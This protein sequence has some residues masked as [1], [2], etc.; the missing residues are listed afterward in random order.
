MNILILSAFP[1]EQDYYK[2]TL[3]SQTSF[4]I[5]FIEVIS[6][7]TASATIYLATTGMGTTNA[8]LVLATLA[9]HLTLDA[10]FFS[11][12]AGAIDPKLN[13]GDVVVG[14]DAF[15]AD[16]LSIHDAVIGTPFESALINPNKKEKTPRVYSGNEWLLTS[17]TLP[18]ASRYSLFHGRI[19]TSNHFPAPKELFDQIKEKNSMVI[20]MES[21]AIY[22]AGWLTQLP[23]LAV[24]AV[25]NKLDDQGGDDE[26]DRSDIKSSDHAAKQVLHC[27]ETIT[28]QTVFTLTA[29]L[30]TSDSA[31]DC[32]N[33][34]PHTCLPSSSR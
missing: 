13:I 4:N 22:Q 28:S 20:D 26:V 5:K 6:C 16:I 32:M 33:K 25:S 3:L 27:I 18:L 34:H 21:A 10:V 11:G 9:T 23:V 19:A 7:H 31:P 30:S 8:A 24:R 2:K 17:A 12:T 15:D 14:Q 1:E 29:K